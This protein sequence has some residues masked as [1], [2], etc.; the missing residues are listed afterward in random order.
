MNTYAGEENR[1][2]LFDGKY[3]TGYRVVEF[4]ICPRAPT[5]EEEVAAMLTTKVRGSV[6]SV[7]DFKYKAQVAY[8]CWNNPNPAVASDWSLVVEG[9]MAIEDLWISC[10]T[11]GDDFWLNYYIV[12]E[13]YEFPAW[14]GAGVIAENNM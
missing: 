6:P 7:F 3:T 14:D 12:L 1:L 5:Q 13:K 9:N 4:R 10:Y 2:N 8:A 11:T